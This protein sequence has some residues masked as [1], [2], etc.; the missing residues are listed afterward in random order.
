[1]GEAAGAEQ[2]V[3]MSVTGPQPDPAGLSNIT[4]ID[5]EFMAWVEAM[6]DVRSA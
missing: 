5:P 2:R 6:R 1:M 3:E 4:L